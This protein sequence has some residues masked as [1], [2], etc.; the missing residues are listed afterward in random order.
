LRL[1]P[2]ERMNF[3]S[4]VI[5]AWRSAGR[6]RIAQGRVKYYLNTEKLR[7]ERPEL[8]RRNRDQNFENETKP[9]PN[10]SEV[11]KSHKLFRS[12]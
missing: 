10:Q 4:V 5:P 3:R 9:E 6:S 11:L 12:A 1:L 2:N 8:S 7:A